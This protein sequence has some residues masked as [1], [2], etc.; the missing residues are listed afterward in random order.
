MCQETR[1]CLIVSGIT[2]PMI[3][4]DMYVYMQ[5]YVYINVNIAIYIMFC[6]DYVTRIHVLYVC[7]LNVYSIHMIHMCINHKF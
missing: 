2:K 6:K 4:V 1:T 5:K 3:H 7:K